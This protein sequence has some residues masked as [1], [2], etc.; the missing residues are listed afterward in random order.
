M[1]LVLF[2]IAVNTLG[3]DVRITDY[4]A[5]VTFTSS[6]E[7]SAHRTLSS[8]NH[9]VTARGGVGPVET[10]GNTYGNPAAMPRSVLE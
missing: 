3:E 7:P 4:A 10:A 9:M 6:S 2:P 1:T 8:H 5:V